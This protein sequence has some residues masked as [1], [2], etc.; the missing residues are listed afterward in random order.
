M[1]DEY[2]QQAA[3]AE[4]RGW[5]GKKEEYRKETVMVGDGVVGFHG[6]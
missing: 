1:R 5:R 4:K 3:T 2:G 6:D